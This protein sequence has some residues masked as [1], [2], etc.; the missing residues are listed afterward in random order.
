VLARC[1]EADPTLPGAVPPGALVTQ[2]VEILES[3]GP[4]RHL[5]ALRRRL[6]ALTSSGAGD[7]IAPAEADV[8]EY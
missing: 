2:A 1:Y 6:A 5:P 4:N 3:C 7:G 8:I